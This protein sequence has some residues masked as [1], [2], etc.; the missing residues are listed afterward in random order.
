MPCCV[1]CAQLKLIDRGD[2]IQKTLRAAEEMLEVP[3]EEIE[4]DEELAEEMMKLAG[5]T[6]HKPSESTLTPS[7]LLLVCIWIG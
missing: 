3:A 1:H 2:E 7:G 5:T 4:E 6:T